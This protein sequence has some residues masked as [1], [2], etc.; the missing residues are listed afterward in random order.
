MAQ[1]AGEAFGRELAAKVAKAKAAAIAA[2]QVLMTPPPLP[3]MDT[4][5][6]PITT[7]T[8]A[9]V[10]TS[11]SQVLPKV[12]QP[13]QGAPEPNPQ[14]GAEDTRQIA[15]SM[16]PGNKADGARSQMLFRKSLS[17]AFAVGPEAEGQGV[18]VSRC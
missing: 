14:P 4:P 18:G 6:T 2:S 8:P 13:K 7:T 16:Q 11:Q 15:L 3:V 12:D 5:I 10:V 17:Y 1:A 9:P